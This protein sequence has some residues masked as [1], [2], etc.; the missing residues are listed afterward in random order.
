MR[1]LKENKTKMFTYA[2]FLKQQD[3][4]QIDGDEATEKIT[5]ADGIPETHPNATHL[6]IGNTLISDFSN[7]SV[8]KDLNV[9]MLYNNPNMTSLD[10]L[11]GLELENLSISKCGLDKI[12]DVDLKVEKLVFNEC[13]DFVFRDLKGI[14]GLKTLD[15]REIKK[16]ADLSFLENHKDLLRLDLSNVEIDSLY[17]VQH[18]K[19]LKINYFNNV[20]NNDFMY[21]KLFVDKNFGN[22]NDYW[23]EIVRYWM[24]QAKTTD[25]SGFDV[26]FEE[27]E[28]KEVVFDGIKLP[29]EEI[30]RLFTPDQ[31]RTL[32]SLHTVKKYNL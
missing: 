6:E 12:G 22:I 25:K 17:G 27:G 13:S 11:K 26:L 14:N 32:R 18:T 8:L 19:K 1:Y 4:V 5:T 3:K 24:D 30:D 16:I 29:R 21:H 2:D 23:A 7:L 28:L 20:G 10:G 9:L 15:L 31:A